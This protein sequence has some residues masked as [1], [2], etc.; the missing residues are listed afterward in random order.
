MSSLNAGKI[1]SVS[2]DNRIFFKA[3]LLIQNK[4]AESM[5]K[6]YDGNTTET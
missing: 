6:T 1:K 3:K 2:Q 5:L 4:T